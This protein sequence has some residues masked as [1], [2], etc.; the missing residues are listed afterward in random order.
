[1]RRA[2]WGSRVNGFIEQGSIRRTGLVSLFAVCF[3]VGLTPISLVAEQRPPAVPL[4]AH[5]PYF[6]IWS[7]ND[8]LTD[9]PTR[10]WT[11]KVQPLTGLVRIDGKSYRYMGDFPE[12]TPAL[13]QTSV[14]VAATHTVY[15]FTGAG[16]ALTLI[17]F[18]PAFPQDM[19]LLS[20][21]VTYLSWKVTSDDGKAH[22]VSLLLDASPLLAVNEG[23]EAA[24]WGRLHTA[25]LD[26]LHLGSRDQRVLNRSGDDLRIDWGYFRLC[27]PR[28]ASV[29]TALVP[30]AVGN[31]LAKGSLPV[32]DDAAMPQTPHDHAAHAAVVFP[33]GN[34]GATTV[35]RHVLLS[36]TEGYAIE[37]MERKLRPYW[38]RNNTPVAEM[39]ERAEHEYAE[40]ERRGMQYDAELRRDLVSAGG[41][42]YANL[43]I[44]AYRQT[45]AA[46]KLVA[47]WDGTPYLFA[48]ENFSNGDI[49][50]VDVLYPSAPFFLFFNPRL[51]EAQMTPVMNYAASS[52]WHF[53]FAPHDLGRYPLAN[54]QEYGGGE[55]TEDDQMP[56]EES[57]NLLILAA[58]LDRAESE[59]SGDHHYA[60]KYWPQLTT[61]AKY[62]REKGLDPERQLSTDDFAGH[63]AHNANLS[64]KAIDALGAYASLADA[65]GKHD[66][67]QDYQQAARQ[68]AA[69]WQTMARD[70]D[71]YKLAF[72]VA[73]SWGQ[74]YNLVWDKLLKLDLFPASVRDTEVAFYLKHLNR[75]GL[76][77]DNRK[78]YTKL[79]WEL[80][81]AT[82]ADKPD[83]FQ[84]FMTPLALWVNETPTRVPLTDWYDT[85]TGAQE[86]FQARSVVGGLYVK[87]YADAALTKKWRAMVEPSR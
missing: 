85:K 65:L 29:E 31:F 77:L 17:F 53:P 40:L 30:N 6:S 1:V 64:I 4:V 63:L 32:N 46:H 7:M 5:D 54:G 14:S 43:A 76:P 47:D 73:G 35:E 82:L 69:K 10:H 61:W 67:A 68:M 87:A 23:N 25:S 59:A 50:T 12:E 75:Y 70:G 33:L 66:A 16:I 84:Q 45:L 3:V 72:D 36:Y 26:E 58:A 41:E 79:D 37:L 2:S 9:G 74:K 60:E 48:K 34:V 83:Q 78:D 8:K 86:G 15:K 38:Q 44:L 24:T 28:E 22:D 81:T 42:D 56:V 11:G 49:A 13:N 80:W 51:L 55:R 39:L 52:R 27:V 62:V 19:D 57:G 21:P 20:R 71:H 18:T